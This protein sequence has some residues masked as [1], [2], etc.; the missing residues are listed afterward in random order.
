MIQIGIF[1]CN[2]LANLLEASIYVK[3]CFL[4]LAF[5][6]SFL[7]NWFKWE[8]NLP[9]RSRLN[10]RDASTPQP[11]PASGQSDC[12]SQC[13]QALSDQLSNIFGGGASSNTS[14][15]VDP[16]FGMAY[17]TFCGY[18]LFA[19]CWP[20]VLKLTTLQSVQRWNEMCERLHVRHG[21]FCSHGQ[22][23]T[24]GYHVCSRIQGW[25]FSLD[26][27]IYTHNLLACYPSRLQKKPSVHT[28]RG[29]EPGNQLHVKLLEQQHVEPHGDEYDNHDD[30][31]PAI[32]LHWRH[33]QDAC[34]GLQVRLSIYSWFYY[35]SYWQDFRSEKCQLTCVGPTLM[36]QCGKEGQRLDKILYNWSLDSFHTALRQIDDKNRTVLW[37]QC[38][39][40]TW[41]S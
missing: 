13:F 20:P 10:C 33:D 8:M 4:G 15:G 35:F 28:R 26:A 31:Q 7:I 34:R 1:L 30:E 36:K 21:R 40:V 24:C 41:Y 27:L 22:S 32:L 29:D 9:F 25:V 14:D 12:A 37:N 39:P 3:V 6:N 5:L 17:D 2:L 11:E 19:Q 23:S 18:G 38:L 16:T